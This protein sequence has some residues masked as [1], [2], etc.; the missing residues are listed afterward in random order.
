MEVFKNTNGK[1]SLS[2]NE[3]YASRCSNKQSK[4]KTQKK[5]I[6]KTLSVW[7][8]IEQLLFTFLFKPKHFYFIFSLR[9]MEQQT[10]D[11]RDWAFSPNLRKQ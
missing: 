1:F 3:H 9:Q 2:D 8:S 6:L 5:S 10:S 4:S 7:F 11:P